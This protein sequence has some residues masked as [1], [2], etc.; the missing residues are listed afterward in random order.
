M[1]KKYQKLEFL[2]IKFNIADV[3]SESV[4]LNFNPNW[5]TGSPQEG[6]IE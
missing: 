2:Y 6:F 4:V 1:K 5:I 3:L